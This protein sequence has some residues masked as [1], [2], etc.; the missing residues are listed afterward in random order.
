MIIQQMNRLKNCQRIDQLIIATS[1]DSSDDQ[2]AALAQGYDLVCYRGSLDNVLKRFYMAAK[3]YSP[4]HIVRLTGDCPIIDP[5]V[6][7]QTIDFYLR[8]DYDYV[9]NCLEPTF[10]D[11]LDAEV[12]SFQALEEAFNEAN[13]PSHL[14]HVTPF[15]NSQPDRYK[16]GTFKNNVDLSN[17]RWTVD[18]PEDFKFIERIYESLFPMNPEFRMQDVLDLLK[19]MPE[20]ASINQ[21]FQRNEGLHKSLQQDHDAVELK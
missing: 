12:F 21:D 2:L 20:L 9:S 15:I 5:E 19:E 13:L 18:E 1:N 14:E 10:P 8:G 7:D 11:G 6:I 16:I 17:M 4:L 3:Q